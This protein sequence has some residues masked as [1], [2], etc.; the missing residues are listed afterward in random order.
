MLLCFSACKNTTL[1]IVVVQDL[2]AIGN[3]YV[4]TCDVFHNYAELQI[5]T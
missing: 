1:A 5:T 3:V 4:N 2:R